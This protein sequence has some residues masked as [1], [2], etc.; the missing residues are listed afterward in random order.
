[1]GGSGVQRPLKFVKYLRE[2]GWNPIV[3]CPEPGA[4][5]AFDDSLQKELTTLNVEVHR[6]KGKTL[7][8]K[9]GNRKVNLSSSIE[10]YLR[11]V[12]QFFWFPDNKK[13]WI[14]PGFQKA[15][16]IIADKSI[17]LV[18]ATA[19]P[20]SNLILAK[21]I[22]EEFNIP[23]VMDLRDD[24]LESHLLSY[25]TQLHYLKMSKIESE[26]LKVA[27]QIIAINNLIASAVDKRNVNTKKVK[28]ISH[29]F[30]PEDFAF[31]NEN[32]DSEKISFLY[33]GTF[34]PESGP[35][36]FIEAMALFLNEN[37]SLNDK[38]ELQFQGNLN[39]EYSSL[40][41]QYGLEKNV[42]NFG[43]LPHS[44][45]VK[46]LMKADV[47]WLNNSHKKNSS[48]LSLGKTYEYMASKKPIIALVPEGDIKDTLKEYGF[49]YISDPKDI[50]GLAKNI[51]T[52]I[53]LL[54][55]EILP[56]PNESFINKFDRRLLTKKL[57]SI[58]NVIT[59]Y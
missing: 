27:D 24:W 11:K 45:A 44:E 12:S 29:G 39:N 41:K 21:K 59:E 55:E 6:V 40:F 1:M 28:V 4:Y 25:P 30:D 36:K 51:E 23:V 46:N 54:S 57:V 38:I 50:T 35:E 13:G 56:T 47:L 37:S 53:T 18:F 49:A 26:T 42:I 58:F 15:K 17:D 8:H 7:L 14:K 52:V 3:L 20:Y 43:F 48:T 16:E 34:Y 9:S 2:F 32:R 10:N 5:H 33:S 31:K 22:K 19:P